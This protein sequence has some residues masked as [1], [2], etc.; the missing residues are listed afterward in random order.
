LI[1]TSSEQVW[2]R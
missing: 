2:T 1:F